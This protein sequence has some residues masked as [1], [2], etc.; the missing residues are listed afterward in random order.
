MLWWLTDDEMAM[1]QEL[2]ELKGCRTEPVFGNS[3]RAMA[4]EHGCTLAE[5]A[6][7]LAVVRTLDPPGVASRDVR[8]CLLTQAL[9]RHP[10][11]PRL[12]RLIA[13]DPL[14]A[15]FP[16]ARAYFFL[17]D[18]RPLPKNAQPMWMG[19]SIGHWEGATFVV[20]TIGQNGRTWLDMR[21]LPGS[22][23][24]KVTERYTRPTVGHM[25]IEVTVEDPVNYTK[26]ITSKL[27]WTL[28]P[29]DELIES[30]C[31]ENNKDPKHMVGK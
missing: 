11:E 9:Q 16:A 6:R 22:E 14:L 24:M 7:V 21:G 10:R 15:L 27:D 4:R 30:I 1:W 12:H 23:S 19:Y 18:G 2:A 29:D 13:T 31:E 5:V 25:I 3:L 26:P 20:E 8:E 17:A 28:L